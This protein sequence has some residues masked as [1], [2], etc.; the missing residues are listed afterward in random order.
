MRAVIKAASD[1]QV[2]VARATLTIDR[3][4]G[5]AKS[6]CLWRERTRAHEIVGFRTRL[7][8]GAHSTFFTTGQALPYSAY[9][10]TS[11][12]TFS[13]HFSFHLSFLRPGRACFASF[14][15]DCGIESF[16]GFLVL[17]S[18]FQH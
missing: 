13:F 12:L 9:L 15:L 11:V 3:R 17:P 16:P 14:G 5:Q 7:F 2:G 4:R 6:T 1:S 8:P 10:F 18:G